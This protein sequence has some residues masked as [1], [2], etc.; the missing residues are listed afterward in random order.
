MTTDAPE[1]NDM[2]A[3]YVHLLDRATDD[4]LEPRVLAEPDGTTYPA[5]VD[6]DSG[7]VLALLCLPPR[8]YDRKAVN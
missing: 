1:L 2:E 3:A 8:A 4:G 7:E 6:I 5:L